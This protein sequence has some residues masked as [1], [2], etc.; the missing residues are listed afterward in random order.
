MC[1]A[2]HICIIY[3]NSS[4]ELSQGGSTKPHSSTVSQKRK[5]KKKKEIYC[6]MEI[7][8]TV[9]TNKVLAFVFPFT[10][11]CLSCYQE[12][13]NLLTWT[14]TESFH[15]QVLF[16]SGEGV[17]EALHRLRFVFCYFWL[18]GLCYFL[19]YRVNLFQK[20]MG[21]IDLIHLSGQ[22]EKTVELYCFLVIHKREWTVR[23]KPSIK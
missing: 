4:T 22:R 9:T 23:N 18:D 12:G 5:E 13:W 21:L 19:N 10:F 15:L 6:K 7:S 3:H 20:S 16:L 1:I 17:G 11:W 14:F 2:I 8:F